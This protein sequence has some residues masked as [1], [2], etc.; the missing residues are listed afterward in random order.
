MDQA[1]KEQ[2]AAEIAKKEN[3]IEKLNEE[4]KELY[5]P[6]QEEVAEMEANVDRMLRDI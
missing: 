5:Q 4:L 2:V 1:K 3:E 6:S